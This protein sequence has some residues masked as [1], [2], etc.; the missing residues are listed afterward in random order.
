MRPEQSY[1]ETNTA[2]TRPET[3]SHPDINSRLNINTAWTRPDK[4]PIWTCLKTNSHPDTSGDKLPSGHNH[5]PDTYGDMR[6]RAFISIAMYPASRSYDE[7]AF[8]NN[9]NEESEKKKL[10]R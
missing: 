9:M 7:Q 1:L 3:N 2:R 4:T 5:R 8:D 10:H 6:L